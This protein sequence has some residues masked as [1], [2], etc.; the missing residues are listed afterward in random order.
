MWN[1]ALIMEEHGKVRKTPWSTFSSKE[2]ADLVV[3][4]QTLGRSR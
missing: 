4:L 3:Y 2:M 1:H